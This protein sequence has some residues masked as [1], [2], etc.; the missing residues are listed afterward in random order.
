MG[1]S[2]LERSRRGVYML[3]MTWYEII[4]GFIKYFWNWMTQNQCVKIVVQYTH[5]MLLKKHKNNTITRSKIDSEIPRSKFLQEDE[6]FLR[7]L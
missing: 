3:K 2:G 1:V 6:I 5:S 4:I 7:S